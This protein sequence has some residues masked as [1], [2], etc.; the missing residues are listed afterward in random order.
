MLGISDARV[1]AVPLGGRACASSAPALEATA[2]CGPRRE[3]RPRARRRRG[4]T[5][6]A[7]RRCRRDARRVAGARVAARGADRRAAARRARRDRAWRWSSRCARCPGWDE[8]LRTQ[9]DRTQNPDRKARF[10]FVMPALSA[11]P[12]ERERAF[13]AFAD[14]GE[15]PPRAVGAR[16]A[17]LSESSAAR[18]AR[19]AVRRVP[20]STCCARFSRPATSS[21]RRAGWSR[22]SPVTARRRWAAIVR[23]FL[24]ERPAYPA[25]LAL[26]DSERGRRVVQERD[27]GGRR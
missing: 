3:P 9:L 14:R 10:A 18:R 20:R 7:T 26:D 17:A 27:L 11:D 23:Q 4:S 12:A 16:I 19:A 25:A 13:D 8:I 21:F 15:P 2:A 5:P 6:I 24:A 1:L 22:R